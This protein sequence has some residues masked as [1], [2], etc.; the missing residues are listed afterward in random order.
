MQT[1][2]E[3]FGR[4]RSKRKG[5]KQEETEEGETSE[6]EDFRSFEIENIDMT[7]VREQA[8]AVLKMQEKRQRRFWKKLGQRH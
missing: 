7:N 3:S 6:N 1:T 4:W 8:N 2:T 5:N